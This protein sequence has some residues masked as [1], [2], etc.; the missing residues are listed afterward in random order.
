MRFSEKSLDYLP[1]NIEP[2]DLGITEIEKG[3]LD[4]RAK[5]MTFPYGYFNTIFVFSWAKGM[6][7][8]RDIY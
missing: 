3:S 7:Y 4:F 1:R 5:K 8:Q 6:S 2:A